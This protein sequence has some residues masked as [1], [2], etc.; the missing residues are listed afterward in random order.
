MK[1]Y[2][3]LLLLCFSY[4]FFAT[5]QKNSDIGIFAGA[6]YYLGDINP[7]THF[8]KAQP[9][10]GVLF[11]YNVNPRLSVRANAYYISLSG[12]DADFPEILHPDRLYSPAV[13]KTSFLDAALQVE[14]NFLP[15]TPG[16]RPFDFTPYLTTGISTGLIMG[17][18]AGAGNFASLPFGAGIKMTFTKRICGGMEYSFRKTF[19]DMI[20][21]IENPSGVSSVI[22]NNDWY[23]YI[24]V[25]ITY[26]FYNFA[27]DCPAYE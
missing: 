27:A 24:G 7:G 16:I 23:S 15:Y 20:D 6:S 17:S 1:K 4:N 22:H 13:F 18:D 3:L 5:A 9:A 14:F 10:F 21:G 26:K 2:T 12:S 25:F 19:N 11:R 8:Y